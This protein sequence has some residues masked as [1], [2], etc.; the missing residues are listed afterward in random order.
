MLNPSILKSERL[1][2]KTDCRAMILNAQFATTSKIT[3]ISSPELIAGA[4]DNRTTDSG[5]LSGNLE[6]AEKGYA[7]F[8][9]LS[10]SCNIAIGDYVVTSG[11]GI[12]PEGLLIGT[13]QSIGSDEYN[14]SIYAS[15]KP[16]VD[17]EEIRDVMVIIDFEGQG[18]L[19]VGGDSQ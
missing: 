8:Y 4:L 2:Q 16:F 12:F 18:G 13:I 19:I 11:E 5:L 17:I 14:T 15:V 3:T 10:R 7:K 6:F 9:N 1:P